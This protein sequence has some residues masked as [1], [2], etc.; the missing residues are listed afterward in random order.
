MAV[1]HLA[2]FPAVALGV[3]M[4]CTISFFVWTYFRYGGA[5]V[6]CEDKFLGGS[7]VFFTR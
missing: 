1:P 5:P 6:G 3:A 4:A 7:V 2:V